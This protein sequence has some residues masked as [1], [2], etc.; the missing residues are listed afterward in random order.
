MGKRAVYDTN[1]QA[2][3]S[4]EV[5]T[6]KQEHMEPDFRWHLRKGNKSALQQM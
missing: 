4:R 6:S 2:C 1:L 3:A 5:H